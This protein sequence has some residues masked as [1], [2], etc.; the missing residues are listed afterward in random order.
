[1]Q[2]VA[3]LQTKIIGYERRSIPKAQK[4]N[5]KIDIKIEG[6]NIENTRI[7]NGKWKSSL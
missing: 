4:Q 6:T 3:K 2:F 1:M 5:S 7:W